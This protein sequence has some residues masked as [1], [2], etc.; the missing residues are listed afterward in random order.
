M[1]VEVADGMN[2]AIDF[3][4]SKIQMGYQWHLLDAVFCASSEHMSVAF[5]DSR[6]VINNIDNIAN[7]IKLGSSNKYIE[8]APHL[9]QGTLITAR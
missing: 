3:S 5:K 7:V 4:S 1:C 9:T 8:Q 2:D 6:E